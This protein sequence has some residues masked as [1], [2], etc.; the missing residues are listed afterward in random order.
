MSKMSRIEIAPGRAD[1]CARPDVIVHRAHDV[2]DTLAPEWTALAAEASE[3][4]PFAEHWFVAAS[5]AT[6]HPDRDV[7]LLEVRRNGRLIGL[8]LLMFETGYGH[9]PVRHVRNWIHHQAFLGTPLVAAGE[10]QVFWDAVLA[11]LNEADWAPGLLY[12][13]RIT[14]GG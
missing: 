13:W 7:R 5:L 6:L 2:M 12:L 3:P 10:E 14:E 9:L 8:L 4:N 1:A 11:T